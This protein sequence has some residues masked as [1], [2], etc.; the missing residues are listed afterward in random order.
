MSEKSPSHPTPSRLKVGLAF[1]AI[2]TIWGSTYLFIRFGVES[3]PPF[4]MAGSRFLVA[5]SILYGWMRWRGTPTPTPAQWRSAMFIGA[6]LLLVGNGGVTWAEQAIPSGVTA[7]LIS[8]SPIWFVMLDWAWFGGARP[9][10]KVVAGL[11]LGLTGVIWLIGPDRIIH[12]GGFPLSGIVV[13]MIATASWAGGSLYS[14]RASLP[15]SPMMATAIE[16][17]CG[18]LLLIV[19]GVGAGEPWDLHASAITL[20]SLL[21]VAYLAI[22]GSLVGFTAY[23]WLLRVVSPARVSTYAFVNPV[24]AVV[25]G[26]TLGGEEFSARMG[27]AA[28]VIVAGVVLIVSRPKQVQTPAS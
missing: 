23:V 14:R 13:L 1:L 6:M 5:G 7:L 27:L 22:F 4:T 17:L 25:L 28:L 20:K 2:Y 3:I 8:T 11:L 15:P 26:W 19:A 21:S 24:I 16:M 18:G 9:A 12:G 10:R